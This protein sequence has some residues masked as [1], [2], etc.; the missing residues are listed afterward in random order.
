MTLLRAASGSLRLHATA[1]ALDDKEH[2][3]EL[4]A[5]RLRLR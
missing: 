5:R 4:P 1:T 2:S 3:R